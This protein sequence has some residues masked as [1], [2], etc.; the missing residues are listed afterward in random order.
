MSHSVGSL[1]CA[2]CGAR[3]QAIRLPDGTG[4]EEGTQWVCFNDDCSYFREGW[5]WM[6]ERYRAKTSYRYRVLN[7]STGQASPLPVWSETA[8]RDFIIDPDLAGP[9]QSSSDAL[10]GRLGEN[11]DD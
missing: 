7:P 4:W 6:W 9:V 10:P 3:L 8:L 5:E 2:H 1:R 11:D